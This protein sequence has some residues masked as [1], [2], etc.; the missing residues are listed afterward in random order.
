LYLQ[1][2]EVLIKFFF[3]VGDGLAVA[4][5]ERNGRRENEIAS[6]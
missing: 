4:L 6:A 1:V 3:G 2:V 5:Q